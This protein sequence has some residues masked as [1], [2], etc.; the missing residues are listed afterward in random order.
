ME[1]VFQALQHCGYDLNDTD[2]EE[3]LQKKLL[4]RGYILKTDIHPSVT[5]VE[6]ENIWK[7]KIP[8]NLEGERV[9][10]ASL[11][12]LIKMKKAAGRPKDLE[13]LRYL[14]KIR[15]LKRRRKKKSSP[16]EI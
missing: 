8:Y 1:K 11:G 13:D 14:E 5:G 4:F 6:W 12:D 16:H 9:Y 3:A 2:L 15:S 7:N 10:F